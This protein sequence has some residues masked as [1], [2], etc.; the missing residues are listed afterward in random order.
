MIIVDKLFLINLVDNIE[1][2]FL[3]N[4]ILQ[5]K[6]VNIDNKKEDINKIESN[7]SLDNINIINVQTKLNNGNIKLISLLHYEKTKVQDET[8]SSDYIEFLDCT[9]EI[10]NN[11]G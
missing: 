3:K 5:N 6:N 11:L 1:M 2:D 7:L 9:Y 4:K 8:Y 10:F